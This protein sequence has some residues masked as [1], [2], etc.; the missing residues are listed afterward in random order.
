MNYLVTAQK[1]VLGFYT[2]P[3][4]FSAYFYGR[5]HATL[6]A[7][8]SVFLVGLLAHY[9]PTL[10]AQTIGATFVDNKW[11]DLTAWAGILIVTAYAMGTLHEHHRARRPDP[12]GRLVALDDPA[13]DPACPGRPAGPGGG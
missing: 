3:T 13:E 1:M 2:L 8:A 12:P 4:L 11:F 9:N 7:V 10:F 6:T 5:R